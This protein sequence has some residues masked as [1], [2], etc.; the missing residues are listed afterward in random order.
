MTVGE[1]IK[2]RRKELGLSADQVAERVGVN[3][4]TI[5]RYESD[6]IKNMGTE[7][8]MPLAA[9]LRTTPAWLLMGDYDDMMDARQQALEKAFSDRP[10]M[11][12][13]FDAANDLDPEDVERFAK[14]MIAFK[15]E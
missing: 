8:L 5:Y 10:D 11:R 14:M 15:G 9:A 2:M 7:T 4:A 6:E 12:I 13:L 1:R 3:R